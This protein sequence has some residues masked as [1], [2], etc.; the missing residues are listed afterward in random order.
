MSVQQA[1]EMVRVEYTR[2]I[3]PMA[4]VLLNELL[5]A[6]EMPVEELRLE[7]LV[8]LIERL[9]WEIQSERRRVRFQKEVL[10]QL[11]ALR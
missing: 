6:L 1:L 11:E 8:E 5:A 2:A 9:S 7:K 10:E 4:H 3:G